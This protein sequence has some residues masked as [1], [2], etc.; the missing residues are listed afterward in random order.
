MPRRLEP[1]PG[2]YGRINGRMQDHAVNETEQALT[3]GRRIGPN[4]LALLD[5]MAEEGGEWTR[6]HGWTW[7][8]V[9][10]T[11]RAMQ[12][13]AKRGAVTLVRDYGP[14]GPALYR[15]NVPAILKASYHIL[16]ANNRAHILRNL[17][18]GW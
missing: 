12:R 11:E 8:T 10:E 16:P 15:L 13:L 9:E 17:K 3:S 6:D 1:I 2:K 5:R 7:G 14:D 18:L 4:M